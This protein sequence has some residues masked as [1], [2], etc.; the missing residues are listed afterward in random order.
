MTTVYEGHW[1]GDMITGKGMYKYISGS[2]YVGYWK[3]GMYDGYGWFVN[4]RGVEY[5]GLWKEGEAVGSRNKYWTMDVTYGGDA[6]EL[7]KTINKDMKF[8]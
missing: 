3:K 5:E 4:D 8:S 2:L 6:S 1:E 7:C